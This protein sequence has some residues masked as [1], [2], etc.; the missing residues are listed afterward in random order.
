MRK[1]AAALAVVALAG[2]CAGDD[3]D[4]ASRTTTT[5]STTRPS[6]ST[7]ST[8]EPKG[9]RV[10][11]AVA[12]AKAW[13]AAVASGDDDTA[14]S[15]LSTRSRDAIGGLDGYRAR[16]IELAEGWGAWGRATDA[17]LSAHTLPYPPDVEIVILHGSVS[18]EGPPRESWNALPVVATDD[19]DRVEAFLDFGPM[20]SEP[21]EGGTLEEGDVLKVTTASA[22]DVYFIIDDGDAVTP[23]LEDVSDRGATWDYA[24]TLDAGLH[25]VTAVVTG[26]GTQARRFEFNVR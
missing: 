4:A 3:D 10:Q 19:G 25:A 16:K 24:P 2:A 1:L 8:T 22:R 13:L 18:Q 23:V 5:T 14:V 6:I 26:N 12:T 21:A 11:D 17:E 9:P 7:T 15:L 20:T